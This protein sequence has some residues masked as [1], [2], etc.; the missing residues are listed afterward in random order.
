VTKNYPTT[1]HAHTVE[2]RLE[3]KAEISKLFDSADRAFRTGQGAT[4]K[5][6]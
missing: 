3:S 1:T 5:L 6:P 4:I 2:Y